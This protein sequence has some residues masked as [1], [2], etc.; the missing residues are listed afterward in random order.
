[1]NVEIGNKAAHSFISGNI[2][3]EFS[4]QGICNVPA[5]QEEERLRE[6]T[7]EVFVSAMLA[8]GGG[9]KGRPVL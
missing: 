8:N 6:R 3:F 2:C 5:R 7:G 1:M 9:E 4:V